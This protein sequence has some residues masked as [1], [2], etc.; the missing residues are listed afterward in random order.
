MRISSLVWI[1]LHSL[2][3]ISPGVAQTFQP[4]E[5]N[6]GW[7]SDRRL[8]DIQITGSTSLLPDRHVVQP[9][10]QLRLRL[11][12]AYI[13]SFLRKK[14]PGFELLSVSVDRPTQLPAALLEAVAMKGGK[15]QEDRNVPVVSLDERIRRAVSIKI[16]SD[17]S[18]R[19]L[20]L[21]D[22]VLSC[23]EQHTE[24]GL[25]R[26]NP[27]QSPGCRRPLF[28]GETFWLTDEVEGF[29]LSI[30]CRERERHRQC[31]VMMP[32]RGFAISVAFEREDLS[33]WR[34]I[35]DFVRSFLES[36]RL[37]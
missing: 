4:V 23:I 26:I 31:S 29:R 15:Q 14:D 20:S 24:D 12:R 34:E 16:I 30:V 25:S 33:K 27:A 13:W 36:K 18:Y 32:F 37:A 19:S 17:L 22:G 9:E 28:E 3:M 35:V 2:A 6:L 11:E 10:R 5:R 8:V 7:S 21:P 1:V